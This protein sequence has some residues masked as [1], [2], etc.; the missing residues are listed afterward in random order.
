MVYTTFC[1]HNFW[2]EAWT[3]IK[4]TQKSKTIDFCR[5]FMRFHWDWLE[6][7]LLA[8]SERKTQ[9]NAKERKVV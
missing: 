1:L 6:M 2:S 8:V 5:I 7:C 9:M 4:D 3:K